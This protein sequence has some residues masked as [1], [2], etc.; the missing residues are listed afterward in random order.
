MSV[1]PPNGRPPTPTQ[2][3]A[4]VA[5]SLIDNFKAS[6]ALL[7]VI[8]L[9]LGVLI[10]IYFGVREQAKERHAEFRFIIERCLK[11]TEG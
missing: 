5:T 3:L 10:F 9:N 8:V 2:A 11:L 4:G 6:P 1:Q 7:A